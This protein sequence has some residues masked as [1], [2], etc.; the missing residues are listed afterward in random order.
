MENYGQRCH[1]VEA[2][3]DRAHLTGALLQD[4]DLARLWRMSVKDRTSADKRIAT[5]PRIER[6]LNGEFCA[7]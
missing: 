6:T 4:S 1:E 2:T 5:R 3:Q 7:I